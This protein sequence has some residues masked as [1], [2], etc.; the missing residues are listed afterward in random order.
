[1]SV[2]E[3][4]VSLEGLRKGFNADGADLEVV[5]VEAGDATIQLIGLD[6]TCWDCIVPP[7]LLERVVSDTV[8]EACPDITHITLVDPRR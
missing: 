1:M 6:D 4:R 2:D 3:V 8:L 7:D 5:S